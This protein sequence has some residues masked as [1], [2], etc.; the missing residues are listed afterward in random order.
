M[1]GSLDIRAAAALGFIVF[2]IL[3]ASALAKF[4]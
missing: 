3:T 4:L 1:R 2:A